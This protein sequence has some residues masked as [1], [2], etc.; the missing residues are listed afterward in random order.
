MSGFSAAGFK[1]LGFAFLYVSQK[2]HIISL[3]YFA[4]QLTV[5]MVLDTE[6]IMFKLIS[7]FLLIRII[8]KMIK[9]F[10]ISNQKLDKKK[11][12]RYKILPLYDIE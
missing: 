10:V 11:L 9:V 7:I 12:L 1:N 5:I 2:M 6:I 8:K 3:S 4:A